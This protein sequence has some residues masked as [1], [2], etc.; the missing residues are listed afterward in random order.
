MDKGTMRTVTRGRGVNLVRDICRTGGE[1]SGS[2]LQ[3]TLKT[4][5]CVNRLFP[6]ADCPANSYPIPPSNVDHRN[7]APYRL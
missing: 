3:D 2:C 6:T 4:S 7:H 1:R 5:L